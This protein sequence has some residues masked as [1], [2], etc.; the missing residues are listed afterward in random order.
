MVMHKMLIMVTDKVID[1]GF[2]FLKTL[3][4]TV[5]YLEHEYF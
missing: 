1:L 3:L 2:F 5:F 4:Y